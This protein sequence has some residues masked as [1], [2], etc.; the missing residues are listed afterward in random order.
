MTHTITNRIAATLAAMSGL[1][2][3]MAGPGLASPVKFTFE[4]PAIEV[5]QICMERENDV[6][7]IQRW[8]EW[9]GKSLADWNPDILRRQIRRLRELDAVVWYDKLEAA[10]RLMPTIDAGFTADQQALEQIDLM[11]AAGR[12]R[13]LT[14]LQLVPT[15]MANRKGDSP[16]VELALSRFLRN[17]QGIEANLDKGL[18]LLVAAAMGGNADALLEIVAM[19]VAGQ[20]IPNWDVSPDLAVTMAFGALVGKLDPMICDRVTR[21]AREYK[22]G[23]VVERDME[24][25]ERWYRFAADLGDA[26]AAWKVA[27]LHMESDELVKD[28]DLLVTYLTRAAEGG[29]PFAIIALG[30]VY[31]TGALVP[32]DEDRAQALYTEAAK[33]GDRG[34]LIRLTQLLADRSDAN[35]RYREAF[36]QALDNLVARNDAPTWALLTKADA[37][38]KTEGR[39]AGEAEALTYLDRAAERGDGNGIVRG[40]EMRFRYATE[41]NDFYAGI[42]RMIYSVA[43]L[44]MN[45]PAADLFD[46]YICRSPNAPQ[47]DEAALW[48]E[49][50]ASKASKTVSF[51]LDELKAL[52]ANPDPLQLA[53]LQ[54][55]ALYG[56]VTATAQYLTYLELSGASAFQKSFWETY[57]RRFHGVDTARARILLDGGARGADRARAISMLRSE[58]AAGEVMAGLPLAGALLRPVPLFDGADAPEPNAHD[59]AEALGL[60]LPIAR[61]GVGEALSLLP[62]AAPDRFP[63]MASVSRQFARTIDARGDFDALLLAIPDLDQFSNRPNYIRRAL[64]ITDCS[65]EQTIQMADVLGQ[66]GDHEGFNKWIGISRAILDEDSWQITLLGDRLRQYGTAEQHAEGMK[67]YQTA[68]EMRS[69]TA[70]QRLLALASNAS[71]RDYDPR[72]ASRLYVELLTD[73]EPNEVVQLLKRINLEDEEIRQLTLARVSPAEVYLTAAEKGN[74]IAMREYARIIRASASTPEDVTEAVGW[75]ARAAELNDAPAMLDY[76]EMLAFGAG[77]EPSREEAIKWLK[78]AADLGAPQANV[79][80]Q[81]LAL[82]GGQVSQ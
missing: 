61:A 41:P 17:G 69:R 11:I 58:V 38:L 82:A 66:I 49:V 77:V 56:R 44:G 15:L 20:T 28:N 12:M 46:A 22:N 35:P 79:M 47:S 51:A 52:A 68:Y 63:D 39:W 18:E 6:A 54:S 64:T 4:P 42:D 37:I 1:L 16:R 81:S 13:E 24:L 26:D 74:A 80:L 70:A 73:A 8:T 76:A 31:E 27:E 45:D 62:L 60:L 23:D 55:Q 19:Q 2:G 78:K 65:F 40:A 3:A 67:L 57:S 75:F 25:A 29:A 48:R 34:A 30:R 10:I 7:I 71:G 21:I 36:V 5:Q 33:T 50:E 43:E 32:K 72:L 53:S 14:A 59:R 9:D